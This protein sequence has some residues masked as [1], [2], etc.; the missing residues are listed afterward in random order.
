[1]MLFLQLF[2]DAPADTTSYMIAG[3]TIIFGVM[4]IYLF[5]LLIRQRNLQKD[6]EVLEEIQAEDK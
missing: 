1:M 4:L 3:Y 5:S 6:M 2:Q